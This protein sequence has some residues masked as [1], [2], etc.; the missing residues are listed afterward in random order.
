MMK[1]IIK[2]I[3]FILSVLLVKPVFADFREDFH[4][5]EI[6]KENIEFMLSKYENE[7][8]PVAI[9]YLGVC[10]AIM[11]QYVFLPTSKLKSFYDGKDK[12]DTSIEV[13]KVNGEQ[14]YLR[15]LV[16]L[17]APSFLFYNGNI[18]ADLDVFIQDVKNNN[19][20]KKWSIVFIDNL[21]KG[22]KL[23]TEQM[24]ELTYLKKQLK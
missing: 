14:R 7:N 1:N 22:K 19:I 17:N 6:N 10:R 2:L 4:N 12:I 9:A 11:A 13:D 15:L 8:A 16:Q 3:F 21:L 23:S 18:N 5:N 20:D 24:N